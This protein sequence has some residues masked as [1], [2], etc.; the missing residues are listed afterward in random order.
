[1]IQ[2]I[3]QKQYEKGFYLQKYLFTYLFA[4]VK[5]DTLLD[6]NILYPESTN[7]PLESF[8]MTTCPL[9]NLYACVP[10][11]PAVI[12]IL[13]NFSGLHLFTIIIQKI[14]NYK[15]LSFLSNRENLN[16]A[17]AIFCYAENDII[18]VKR[19]IIN[20]LQARRNKW[21]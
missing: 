13:L 16:F 17:N 7:H 5:E 20:P 21:L 6:F 9:P 10:P 14:L 15:N 11:E 12:F 4:E 3:V 1:M 19:N 18:C 8:Q 2:Q